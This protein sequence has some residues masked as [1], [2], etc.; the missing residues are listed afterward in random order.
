MSGSLRV[1]RALLAVAD[2]S[3]LPAL[4]ARLGDLGVELVSTG[5][6]A[7]AISDAGIPVTPVSDVT[8][9]PEM[10]D[11][12]VK[13][14]HPRIHAG[15]LADRR[16]PDHMAQLEQHG[17]RPF[18][19][20][21]VNLYP[22]REAVAA[23]ASFD[24]TIEQIDIGGPAMVRAAAKNFESVAV[25]VSPEAYD[26]VLE[27]LSREGGLS[28]ETRFRLA[29]E[30]FAHT[31]EYDAAISAWLDQRAAGGAEAEGEAWPPERLGVAMSLRESLRYGENP[32]QRAA[33]YGAAGPPAPLGDAR[34]LQGKEMSFNNWLDAEAARA[35][36]G[37][38][39]FEADGPCAAIVK[40]HNPCGVALG[41][42][43][44]EA[45]TKALDGDRVS[46]FGGI[47]AFNGEVDA[48]AAGS[49][50][51][52]FTEVVIA[53]GYAEE[54]LLAFG[55]RQNL[56]VVRAALPGPPVLDIR[57]IDGGALLQDPD[58]IS[59]AGDDMRVVTAT[60]PTEEQWLDLLFAWKVAARVKSNGIVLVR[61]LATV[62][63]GAGQMNR[64]WSVDIASRQAGEKAGGAVLASD[65][66]FPFR[67]GLDRA[68]EA[69]VVA[70]IQ[71]G[72]SV[73]DDEV[74]AAAEEHGMA[75][76]Y[77]GRRHFRH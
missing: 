43:F 64:L 27:E 37:L 1:R 59:E 26:G 75:M 74:V 19:L 38:F 40:H 2:K 47:V 45:Y 71:P 68:A 4:A 25:V 73:R 54:A 53:P 16:K 42:T 17:I 18:D 60:R 70:V 5:N 33:L 58:V 62:G 49:M 14:L 12:R 23:G 55:A 72:G 69:G 22:F 48:A 20:V 51:D 13:T 65:A 57:L 46:A 52:V 35:V 15:L 76:V 34:V 61:D 31:A 77:T 24:E 10:L 63:V 28:R 21:V 41:A 32:H 30:A 50:A 11:G 6:T 7:K 56:R 67:D 8:G 3:G 66:F 29:R 36:A 44:A 9:F 39:D